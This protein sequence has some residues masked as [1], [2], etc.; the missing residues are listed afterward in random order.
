LSNPNLTGRVSGRKH[1]KKLTI[2][3]LV[4][5]AIQKIKEMAE[6][7]KL[8]LPIAISPLSKKKTIPRKEKNTPKPVRPSPISDED[9][10]HTCHKLLS[11]KNKLR[12]RLHSP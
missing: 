12:P 4:N 11:E 7:K 2:C 3:I 6:K 9:K 8:T 1:E 5:S 10:M